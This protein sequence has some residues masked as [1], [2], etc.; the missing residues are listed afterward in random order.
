MAFG[1]VGLVFDEANQALGE[2][3]KRIVPYGT[4]RPVIGGVAVISLVYLFGTRDYLGL[5]TLASTPNRLTIASFFG[6]DTHP[7]FWALKLLFT[8]VQ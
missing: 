4:L 8:A 2:W 5:G 6:L 3:L 7:W 1:P